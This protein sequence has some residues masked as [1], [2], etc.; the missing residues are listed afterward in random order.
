MG[1]KIRPYTTGS[2]MNAKSGRKE[3]KSFKKYRGE[4]S[5]KNSKQYIY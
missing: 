4:K 2:K 5:A 1:E 3:E